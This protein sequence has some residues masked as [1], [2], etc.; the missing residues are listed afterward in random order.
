M[1]AWSSGKLKEG[2]RDAQQWKAD[3][4]SPHLQCK[5]TLWRDVFQNDNMKAEDQ[6]ALHAAFVETFPLAV[7]TNLEKAATRRF[8]V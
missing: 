4:G 3:A 7:S 1:L 5:D 2:F 8:T 6:K